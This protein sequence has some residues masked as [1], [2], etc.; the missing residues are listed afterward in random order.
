MHILS[1][2]GASLIGL[3]TRLDH[4]VGMRIDSKNKGNT[5]WL[6]V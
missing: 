2:P 3:G 6:Y 1:I 4:G 5:R